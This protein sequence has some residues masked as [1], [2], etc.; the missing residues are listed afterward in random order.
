MANSP[1]IPLHWRSFAGLSDR[2]KGAAQL[3]K[4]V[5]FAQIPLP[6]QQ[7]FIMSRRDMGLT[8]EQVTKANL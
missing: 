8:L 2:V 5:E 7:R 4:R 1:Q 6:V 3:E